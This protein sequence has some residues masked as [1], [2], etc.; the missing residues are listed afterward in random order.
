MKGRIRII[1]GQWRGR[2]L[3]VPDRPGLRPTGDRVR[4]TLF[5]WLQAELPGASCL[6]LFAGTGA[7]G[8]EALSRGAA[9]AV[10]VERDRRLVDALVEI[11]ESWPGG[12]H[13]E[14]VA[15]DALGWLEHDDR[16]FDL[17]FIDPPFGRALQQRSLDRLV[18]G[19]HLAPAARVYV[20]LPRGETTPV[21]GGSF[22][23]LREKCIGDVRMLL[24]ASRA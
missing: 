15:G 16:R 11:A 12:E 23:P 5:N 20:E 17:V 18:A 14:V 7:L 9:S 19:R 8:L 3:A 22:E 6:D 10:F 24:L 21:A 1:G 2:K 13:M 4:E